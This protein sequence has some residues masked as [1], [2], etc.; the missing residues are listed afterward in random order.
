MKR[1]N[2]ILGI[3]VL[4]SLAFFSCKKTPKQ[5]AEPAAQ[6][7]Q[8]TETVENVKDTTISGVALE[9]GMSTVYLRTFG[10]DTLEFDMEDEHGSGKVYGYSDEGDTLA[11][12]A[13]KGTDGGRVVNE[14]WNMTLLHRYDKDLAVHNGVLY[15][16][17][18]TVRIK[19]LD[20]NTLVAVVKGKV[21]SLEPIYRR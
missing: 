13:R 1:F 3:M 21:I 8:R 6:P 20:D 5:K 12:T 18:D 17:T 19:S 15:R 9:S 2:C 4:M 10:G 7:V 16:G 14:L 11:L